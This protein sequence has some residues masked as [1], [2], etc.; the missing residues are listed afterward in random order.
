MRKKK[1]LREKKIKK[2]KINKII[3]LKVKAK[4]LLIPQIEVKEKVVKNQ[5]IM[6]LIKRILLNK[7]NYQLKIFM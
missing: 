2:K 7:D 3:Y 5:K 6:T 1:K 4:P